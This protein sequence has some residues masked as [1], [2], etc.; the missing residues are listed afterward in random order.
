MQRVG[1]IT[2]DDV[3]KEIVEEKGYEVIDLHKGDKLTD[4]QRD[5]IRKEANEKFK[6]IHIKQSKGS[7]KLNYAEG[8]EVLKPD[9]LEN[10]SIIKE[11]EEEVIYRADFGENGGMNW[12]IIKE[13]G[14]DT[15]LY[16]Y[17]IGKNNRDDSIKSTIKGESVKAIDSIFRLYPKL[18]S[19]Y[20]DDE[21]DGW[22]EYIGGE[23][24]VL[25][26]KNFY[27]F[28]GTKNYKKGGSMADGGDIFKVGGVVKTPNGDTLGK[29][30][31]EG[32]ASNGLLIRILEKES[33][34]SELP[35]AFSV[36]YKLYIL[37]SESKYYAEEDYNNLKEGNYIWMEKRGELKEYGWLEQDIYKERF[38][39]DGY[40]FIEIPTLDNYGEEISKLKLKEISF[41]HTLSYDDSMNVKALDRAKMVATK[42]AEDI[43]IGSKIF[44]AYEVSYEDDNGRERVVV[45]VGLKRNLK[46]GGSM[47]DGGDIDIMISSQKAA[48][49][50]NQ[51]VSREGRE[52]IKNLSDEEVY[53][54]ANKHYLSGKQYVY[55]FDKGGKAY[56]RTFFN[57]ESVV[58]R[59]ESHPEYGNFFY[60]TGNWR[61][62]RK[63]EIQPHNPTSEQ[64]YYY[65]Q[66]EQLI[67]AEEWIEAD[68]G[69]GIGVDYSGYK[70]MDDI[71]IKGKDAIVLTND[72]DK[73][74]IVVEYLD[75][76]TE[77]I[78]YSGKQRKKMYKGGEF[79]SYNKWKS[80]DWDSMVAGKTRSKIYRLLNWYRDERLQ[81][82]KLSEDDN[83]LLEE[84]SWESLEKAFGY[85]KRHE[86]EE[87]RNQHEAAEDDAELEEKPLKKI[88]ASEDYEYLRESM[89]KYGV[90]KKDLE[91]YDDSKIADNYLHEEL[92]KDD[93]F[94][95]DYFLVN[96]D[97]WAD[98][99]YY[100]DYP[101][102]EVEKIY[103][104]I[105]ERGAIYTEEAEQQQYDMFADPKEQ[106]KK[107]ETKEVYGTGTL[108]ESKTYYERTNK[109]DGTKE[110]FS[111]EEYEDKFIKTTP[112]ELGSALKRIFKDRYSLTI[113][114]SYKKTVRGLENSWFEISTWRS[115]QTI[116]NDLRK[117]FL[118]LSSEKPISQLKVLDESDITYGNI[119]SKSVSMYGKYWKKWIKEIDKPKDSLSKEID[120]ELETLN[121]L[122]E[123]ALEDKDTSLSEELKDRIEFLEELKEEDG[124]ETHE[125]GGQLKEFRKII[126]TF[127]DKYNLPKVDIYGIT[128]RGET[129]TIANAA[130]EL[131]LYDTK[132]LT[133]RSLNIVPE[134]NTLGNFHYLVSLI[135]KDLMKKTGKSRL[136]IKN[137][138]H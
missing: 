129:K 81:K 46:D 76:E 22:W 115:K 125:R 96:D 9:Y 42:I 59:D 65:V 8:G 30:I 67:R 16:I 87:I 15:S 138:I 17:A 55:G 134:Y 118:E 77:S 56:S 69:R 72:V 80:I 10:I 120:S 18:T 25:T 44:K 41:A 86:I 106:P 98:W 103:D 84:L 95:T 24:D 1:E 128:K 74:K 112:R 109:K 126:I 70:A 85:I 104:D 20:Y 111:V 66:H 19:V 35:T 97:G 121:D 132:A 48:E 105:I 110:V 4:T 11:D 5:S 6:P 127:N 100:I 21:S 102:D 27:K 43:S 36:Q 29:I 52:A 14:D 23:G 93:D 124:G 60:V 136:M 91:L 122:L 78:D 133:L 119:N 40:T 13:W 63:Y 114:T 49:L 123:D 79:T 107:E 83:Y 82:D 137:S 37:P 135:K 54:K 7:H 47:A 50:K 71:K 12:R 53:Q 38:E 130:S 73:K 99:D 64:E 94:L 68:S 2:Y 92:D 51:I 108:G 31:K 45:T 28:W 61:T 117:R 113:T 39:R 89:A 3:L 57:G 90:T 131:N 116:P 62:D 75:G 32:K 101:Y 58:V 34:S 88:L 33:D 26:K